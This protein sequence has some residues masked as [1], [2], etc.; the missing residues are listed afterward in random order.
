VD[1]VDPHL[2][3]APHRGQRRVVVLRSPAE[4]PASAANRPGSESDRRNFEPRRAEQPFVQRHDL[5][6]SHEKYILNGVL[7]GAKRVKN[8]LFCE[9]LG[10]GGQA[11][12]YSITISLMCEAS[13]P[14]R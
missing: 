8:A 1:P 5:R 3:R 9:S 14:P 4:S 6:F 7:K 12:A 2:D 13:A 11:A 10:S